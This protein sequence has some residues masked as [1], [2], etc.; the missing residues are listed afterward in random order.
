MGLAAR[1]HAIWDR[2]WRFMLVRLLAAAVFAL[3]LAKGF[4]E[5][6]Y[7]EFDRAAFYSGKLLP[8]HRE[9][10][11]GVGWGDRPEL[12]FD[13][14]GTL[15]AFWVE[16]LDRAVLARG[17][18]TGRRW[19]RHGV[20]LAGRGNP[21]LSGL[22]LFSH[23]GRIRLAQGDPSRGIAV[24]A[25]A[26][27][28]ASWSRPRW[29]DH[30]PEGTYLRFNFP[31]LT[32]HGDT[33]F[34][35]YSRKA[36]RY[37]GGRRIHVARSGPGTDRW[38]E[39]RPVPAARASGGLPFAHLQLAAANDGLFLFYGNG[40]Y[41]SRDDGRN[42][43]RVY[44]LPDTAAGESAVTR[45]PTQARLRTDGRGNLYLLWR[46]RVVT[47]DRT[48]VDSG[49]WE[50]FEDLLF[51]RS[52]DG[53]RTWSEPVRINDERLP[54]RQYLSLRLT[55]QGAKRRRYMEG[56]RPPRL[57]GFAVNH[58]GGLAAL[59]VDWRRQ[60]ATAFLAYSVDGGRTWSRNRPVRA[61]VGADTHYAGLALSDDQRLSL[62][63]PQPEG[64]NRGLLFRAWEIV[65]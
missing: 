43:R 5:W 10:L 21:R 29:I 18:E 20:P 19:Q 26:D 62:L 28:G 34:C 55:N 61:E 44:R 48:G 54:F 38:Q 27:G 31:E 8:L 7:P 23:Q 63:L 35:A 65:R 39:S 32:A 9:T 53:G 47:E 59:W 51:S 12:L 17:R 37:G 30:R 6:F 3:L 16:G 24:I 57:L 11:S 40:L 41:R 4:A 58:G 2:I 46:R 52:T 56:P 60:Q 1:S 42:W 33:L 45:A 50:G 13:A 64:D 15:H 49:Y 36:G 14:G 22:S 25:T